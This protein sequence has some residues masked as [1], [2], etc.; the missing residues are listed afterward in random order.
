MSSPPKNISC[1][2]GLRLLDLDVIINKFQ[3]IMDAKD[4][5]GDWLV[6][7]GAAVMAGQ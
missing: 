2:V 4:S 7:R 5:N 3:V 1:H 6:W